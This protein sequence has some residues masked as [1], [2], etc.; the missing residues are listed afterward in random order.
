M[1]RVLS[2]GPA[3]RVV[4]AVR[5]GFGEQVVILD[6]AEIVPGD[7]RILAEL[8]D[9]HVVRVH[10]YVES[11]RALVMEAVDG[12]TLERLIA[13]SGPMAPDAA[14]RVLKGCLLGLAAAHRAGIVHRDLTPAN[15]LVVGGACKVTGFGLDARGTPG[16]VAPERLEGEISPAG[17]LY[18]AAAVLYQCLTGRPPGRGVAA[19]ERVPEGARALIARGM[20]SYPPAR[21]KSAMEFAA[22][23]DAVAGGAWSRAAPAPVN[24]AAPITPPAAVPP[25]ASPEPEPEAAEERPGLLKPMAAV[26]AVGLVCGF[27]TFGIAKAAGGDEPR[28]A[29]DPVV[30]TPPAQ[31]GSGLSRGRLTYLAGPAAGTAGGV[32][33]ARQRI[34]V[35]LT[36][37]PA[38]VHAGNAVTVRVVERRVDRSACP[39]ATAA[40]GWRV[41]DGSAGAL[42][43]YPRTAGLLPARSSGTRLAATVRR[44]KPQTAVKGCART[45]VARSVYAFTVDASTKP[46]AYLLSPWNPPRMTRTAAGTGAQASPADGRATSRG[47]LPALTVR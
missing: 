43:L 11:R 17:D 26:V 32:A 27:G 10:E 40:G 15:V 25:V 47:R 31:P 24:V 30:S 3:G 36:V 45:T 1:V 18:A 13:E 8:R 42:W 9:P 35:A 14:L 41:G 22:L 29:A 20:A 33:G 38:V 12:V 6:R 28:R 5:D 4:E 21:P 2:E 34:D 7:A 44:A 23:V 16:F 39:P 46:G 19:L 37:S